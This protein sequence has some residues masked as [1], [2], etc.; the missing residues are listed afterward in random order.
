MDELL[1]TSDIAKLL[2]CNKNYVGELLKSGLLPYLQ[3][4]SRKVRRKAFEEFLQ[5]YDGWNLSD[6]YNPEIINKRKESIIERN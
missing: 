3:M 6:P 4:G 2:K 5:K 1:T